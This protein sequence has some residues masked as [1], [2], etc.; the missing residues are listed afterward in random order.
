[1]INVQGNPM[2][3]N[4][5]IFFLKYNYTVVKRLVAYIQ[6]PIFCNGTVLN[7]VTHSCRNL[8][9]PR[10]V[11]YTTTIKKTKKVN[12]SIGG[13]LFKIKVSVYLACNLK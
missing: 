13:R 12:I 2:E 5:L 8:S 6:F 1:M 9:L 11:N 7:Y 3:T 10:E 4:N